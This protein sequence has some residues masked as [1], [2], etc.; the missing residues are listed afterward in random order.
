LLPHC[1]ESPALG[2]LRSLNGQRF[3]LDSSAR[4]GLAIIGGLLSAAAFPK[5]GVAGFAWVAPGL[6][7]SSALGANGR[8][9]FRLGYAAGLAYFL[10]S[11][12]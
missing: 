9:A 3:R 2:K 4:V 5:I 7:L 10:T 6:I 11:L 1:E 8:R 12:Y